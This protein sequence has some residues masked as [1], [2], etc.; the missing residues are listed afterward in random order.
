MGVDGHWVY[1]R[2]VHV[3]PRRVSGGDEGDKRDQWKW[4]GKVERHCI[5]IENAKERGDADNML[6]G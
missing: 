4:D 6:R 2:G 1:G 3:G 5:V